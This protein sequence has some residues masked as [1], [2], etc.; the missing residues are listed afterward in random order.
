MAHE[1]HNPLGSVRLALHAAVG[2]ARAQ[3]P[4]LAEVQTCLGLV[5]QEVDT[6]IQVTQRLLRLSVPRQTTRNWWML[7]KWWTTP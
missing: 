5:D 3:P 4:D 1:I 2:A 6:C 7:L